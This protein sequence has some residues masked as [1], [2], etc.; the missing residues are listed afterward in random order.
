MV[1]IR[2]NKATLSTSLLPMGLKDNP[3]DLTGAGGR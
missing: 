2:L 3:E 1:D